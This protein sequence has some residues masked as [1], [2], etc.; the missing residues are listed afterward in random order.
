MAAQ[1]LKGLTTPADAVPQPGPAEPSEP[2]APV[3]A[4]AIV[5]SWRSSR[6][7]GSKFQ[8]TLGR[9]NKFVWKFN[10]ADKE[11]QMTGN[12]TLANNFLILSASD[13]NSLVG[14]VAMLPG[15]KLQFRLSGGNPADPGLT[16]TR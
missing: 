1:L 12:Y 9:D 4:A 2:A 3:D 15:D 16:F 14:Q 6:P 7:D 8:L 11:Q 13:K 5:G 10:Q